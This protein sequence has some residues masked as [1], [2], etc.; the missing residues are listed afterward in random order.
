MNNSKIA[1][2]LLE[3]EIDPKS[4]LRERESY[5][6]R[7]IEAIGRVSGTADWKILK[8]EIFD[9]LVETLERRIKSETQK[10]VLNDPELYRLQGQL[11]WAKKF[12]RLEELAQVF[13]VELINIRKQIN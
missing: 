8:N 12:S 2:E 7:V 4:A 9:S 1:L 11:G 13:K 5:L 3:T 6:V 10:E